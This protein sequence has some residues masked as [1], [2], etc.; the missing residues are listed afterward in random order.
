LKRKK[1]QNE[2]GKKP[3]GKAWKKKNVSRKRNSTKK[4]YWGNLCKKGC[5]LL[6]EKSLKKPKGESR[7]VKRRHKKMETRNQSGYLVWLE[8]LRMVQSPERRS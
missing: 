6:G 5:T 4:S 2:E 3:Y 8:K 7:K 1:K